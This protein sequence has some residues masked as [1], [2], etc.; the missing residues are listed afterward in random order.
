[1]LVLILGLARASPALALFKKNK[2]KA[3]TID[4]YSSRLVKLY[5]PIMA[6][7]GFSGA[8]GLATGL[9]LR[10]VGQAVAIALGIL[11][12]IIQGG[13]YLGFVEVKWATVHREV[14]RRLDINRDGTF[15]ATDFKSL[16]ASSLAILSQGVPSVGGFLAGFALAVK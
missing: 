13:A 11:F 3:D 2:Q 5:W 10:A 9:A 16:L 6:N 15:D 7:L 1:M 12:I 8:V 14:I 4:E